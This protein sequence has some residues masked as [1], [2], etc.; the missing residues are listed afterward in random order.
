MAVPLPVL[1][2]VVAK[3]FC[4]SLGHICSYAVCLEVLQPLA[5]E[6]YTH[7]HT[8]TKDKSRS[9]R[10][11][12][13]LNLKEETVKV[14]TRPEVLNPNCNIVEGV[15]FIGCIRCKVKVSEGLV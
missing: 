13:M 5:T 2:L 14:I 8:Q 10:E 12:C 15:R 11:P 1:L 3:K 4:W 7:T 9:L 6:M